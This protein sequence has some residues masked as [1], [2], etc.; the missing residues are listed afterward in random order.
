MEFKLTPHEVMRGIHVRK[1]RLV[2]RPAG[3]VSGLSALD[4]VVGVAGTV[5][6]VRAAGFW[7]IVLP[8]ALF[9]AADGMLR[10]RVSVVASRTEIV[11]RNRWRRH[12][13]ALG[14]F[15]GVAVETVEW[16][17]RS[18]FYVFTRWS[19]PEDWQ[20]GVVHTRNGARLQC[21]AL[22]SAPEGDFVEPSPARMK[23]AALNRWLQATTSSG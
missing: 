13:V 12:G 21:D 22:I 3:V 4:G 11:V 16:W 19:G 18:P 9:L 7:L 1:G 17:F 15:S 6:I 20:V 8:Y 14:D 5:L 10:L 23:V 2:L